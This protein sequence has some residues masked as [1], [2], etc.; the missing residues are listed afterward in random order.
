MNMAERES[1]VMRLRRGVYRMPKTKWREIF[2]QDCS[3]LRRRTLDERIVCR[4]YDFWWNEY[5]NTRPCCPCTRPANRKSGSSW[6]IWWIFRAACWDH[7]WHANAGSVRLSC[8]FMLRRGGR[9]VYRDEQSW[10]CAYCYTSIP[11]CT[12]CI[13]WRSDDDTRLRRKGLSRICGSRCV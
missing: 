4:G 5:T 10:W 1:L 7:W 2:G 6:W 11:S 13:A 9:S 3:K 12:G 8:P